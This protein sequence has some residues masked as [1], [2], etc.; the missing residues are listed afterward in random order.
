MFGIRLRQRFP[1]SVTTHPIR[2]VSDVPKDGGKERRTEA[3][4]N[5]GRLAAS[6]AHEINNP[7]ESLLNLLYLMETEATLTEKGRHYLEMAEAEVRQVSQIAH[8]V[9]QDSRQSA[10]L[11]RTNVPQLLAGVIDFYHSRL[12]AKGISVNTRFRDNGDL[13]VYADSLRQLFSN[14]VLN[15]ADA[16]P[17]GGRIL[18]RVH[19]AQEWNG[20][21][22]HGLRVT[23]AD[24]GRGIPADKLPMILEPFFTTKGDRG[25]GLGLALVK[26]VVQRHRGALRIRSSTRYGHSGSVF[27]IFFPA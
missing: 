18:A 22:R 17:D 7:L 5:E 23:I 11:I 27:S 14:L 10:V 19:E 13:G 25:I 8:A 4:A 3:L 1:N 21:H 2:D 24:N 16:M 6:L 20:E 26:D 15:A 9:L 12:E